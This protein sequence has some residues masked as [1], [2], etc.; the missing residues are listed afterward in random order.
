MVRA[1]QHEVEGLTT[2]PSICAT[3]AIGVIA[4][5]GLEATAILSAVIVLIILGVIPFIMPKTPEADL[6]PTGQND[7]R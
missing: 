5:L 3:A 2:A 4:G 6:L 7:G 1:K